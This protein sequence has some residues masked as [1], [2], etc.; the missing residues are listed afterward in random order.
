MPRRFLSFTPPTYGN[1]WSLSR[2]GTIYRDAG[3]LI[4]TR[5]AASLQMPH[6]HRMRRPCHPVGLPPARIHGL[7]HDAACPKHRG[8]DGRGNLRIAKTPPLQSAF[9][10]MAL[11]FKCGHCRLHAHTMP[12]VETVILYNDAARRVATIFEK[13]DCEIK[14]VLP[15]RRGK[16]P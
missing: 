11:R 2:R 14:T 16:P 6:R 5:H 7:Y 9:A 10:G 8:Q 12:H 15:S 3:P 13:W 4:A 1:L